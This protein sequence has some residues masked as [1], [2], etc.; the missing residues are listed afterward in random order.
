MKLGDGFLVLG[1][2]VWMTVAVGP[3]PVGL[4]LFVFA[5]VLNFVHDYLPKRR[6]E[7]PQ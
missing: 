3:W 6:K 1:L 4:I 7:P 5:F 2:W